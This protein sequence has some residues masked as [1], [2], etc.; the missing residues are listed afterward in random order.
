MEPL[1]LQIFRFTGSTGWLGKLNFVVKDDIVQSETSC[2]PLKQKQNVF[3]SKSEGAHNVLFHWATI[4]HS[5]KKHEAIIKLCD[6]FGDK[7]GKFNCDNTWRNKLRYR[8]ILR[9]LRAVHFSFLAFYSSIQTSTAS[10]VDAWRAHLI[11]QTFLWF[12]VCS[13]SMWRPLK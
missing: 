4:S 9:I 8:I 12:L 7:Y 5:C 3:Y 10:M 1:E 11:Q 13:K 2:T 6:V